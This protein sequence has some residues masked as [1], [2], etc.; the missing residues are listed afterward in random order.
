M[1]N[2][3]SNYYIPNLQFCLITGVTKI[4]R[5]FQIHDYMNF[6]ADPILF[7]IYQSIPSWKTKF[8]T[9]AELLYFVRYAQENVC[10]DCPSYFRQKES[11]HIG[12]TP[13]VIF[14][15][16]HRHIFK[17]EEIKLAIT[18]E[19]ALYLRP[20]CYPSFHAVESLTRCLL[21]LKL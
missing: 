16:T 21:A 14:D 5:C 7:F 8:C 11:C 19:V 13:V 20:K 17:L 3:D 15:F 9:K 4:L 10:F 18:A 6:K 2:N 1:E 12:N